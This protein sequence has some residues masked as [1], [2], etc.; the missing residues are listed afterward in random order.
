MTGFSVSDAEAAIGDATE[1]SRPSYTADTLDRLEHAG[2]DLRS[3]FFITGA[4]AFR[5]IAT[6]KGYPALLDRCHFVVVSRPGCSAGSMRTALPQLSGRMAD[7]SGF[8]PDRPTVFLVDAPTAPVSSTIVRERL[9]RGESIE[10]LVP[11]GVASYIDR[12]GLYRMHPG[13]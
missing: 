9:G 13:D 11:P 10:G 2:L 3:V 8:V 4:D 1:S 7:A 12:H 6:W 5:D